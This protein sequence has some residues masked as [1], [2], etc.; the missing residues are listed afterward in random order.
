MDDESFFFFFCFFQMLFDFFGI[1]QAH[2]YLFIYFFRKA[3]KSTYAY[4]RYDAT[5]S[6]YII[7]RT[8]MRL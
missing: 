2:F 5:S 7:K 8:A 3:H 1:L 6:G 4:V